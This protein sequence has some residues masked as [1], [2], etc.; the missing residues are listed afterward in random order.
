[1][2]EIRNLFALKSRQQLQIK[3]T[4]EEIFTFLNLIQYMYL[5]KIKI[6]DKN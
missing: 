3:R 5:S 2:I 1:M 6:K 4:Y